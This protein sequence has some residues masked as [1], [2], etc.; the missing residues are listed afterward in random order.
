MFLRTPKDK[1]AF[2]RRDDVPPLY[3]QYTTNFN[4]SKR[5][6][7]KILR[8]FFVFTSLSVSSCTNFFMPLRSN[9]R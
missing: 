6:I 8:Y 7:E 1:K 3:L 2:I 9:R 4:E 5:F